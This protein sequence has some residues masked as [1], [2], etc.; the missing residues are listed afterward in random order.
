MSKNEK[1][2]DVPKILSAKKKRDGGDGH[3]ITIGTF[4]GT[5]MQF[6]KEFELKNRFL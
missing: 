1:S 3:L 2:L 4:L 5:V 6:Y